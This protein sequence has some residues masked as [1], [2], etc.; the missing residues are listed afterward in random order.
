MLFICIYGS[1]GIE[2][3]IVEPGQGYY[4]KCGFHF[5]HV[6][7]I[8]TYKF[9]NLLLNHDFDITVAET[10]ESEEGRSRPRPLAR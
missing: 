2:S 10:K 4:I 5:L 6:L 3:S 7:H 9:K 8:A 1:G